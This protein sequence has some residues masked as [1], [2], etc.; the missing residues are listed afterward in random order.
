MIYENGYR[1]DI[2]STVLNWANGVDVTGDY[3]LFRYTEYEYI[4]AQGELSNDGR[5]ITG[6]DLILTHYRR[7]SYQ[8][9]NNWR[10]Q[11]LFFVGDGSVKVDTQF[12][13]VY[14][15]EIEGYAGLEGVNYIEKQKLTTF[16]IVVLTLF[17][18]LSVVFSAVRPIGRSVGRRVGE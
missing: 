14:T 7:T 1:G 4:L 17:L 6:D 11:N 3:V 10:Y 8:E 13:P 9:N 15:N 18:V 16:S 12:S 2:S 5:Y